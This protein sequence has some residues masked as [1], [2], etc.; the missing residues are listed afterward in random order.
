MNH[1]VLHFV[2]KVIKW[3]CQQQSCVHPLSTTKTKK[4]QSPHY[5]RGGEYL[6]EDVPE[7]PLVHEG[8]E[9]RE[10]HREE[11]HE[12][13]ADRQVHDEDVGRTLQIMSYSRIGNLDVFRYLL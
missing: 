12:H 10:G 2:V 7:D 1:P 9:G 5:L 3:P 13:V 4:I 6:A 11:A 8:V